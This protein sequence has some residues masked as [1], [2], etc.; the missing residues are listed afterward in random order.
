M[1]SLGNESLL[2]AEAEP[3]ETRGGGQDHKGGEKLRGSSLDERRSP[4]REAEAGAGCPGP[5]EE[6]EGKRY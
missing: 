2:L 3:P 4:Q 1:E 5:W 6:R